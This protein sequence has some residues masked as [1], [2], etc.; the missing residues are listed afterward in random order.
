MDDLDDDACRIKAIGRRVVEEL[1]HYFSHSE[2]EARRLFAEF[3]NATKNTR[4]WADIDYY[5]H[6]GALGVALEVEFYR[7]FG[8]PRGSG[9]EFLDWRR[10]TV[11]G[12][13]A[14]GLR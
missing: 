9:A 4:G 5:D 3:H 14:A 10:D 13:K 6:E 1:G 7:Q 2:N 12:W 8:R 11:A